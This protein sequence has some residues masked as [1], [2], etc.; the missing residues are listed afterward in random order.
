MFL[1]HNYL[2]LMNAMV[3]KMVTKNRL[4]QKKCHSGPKILRLIT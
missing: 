1:F 2:T 4:K 3:T